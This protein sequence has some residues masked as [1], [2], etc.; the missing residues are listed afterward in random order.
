[1]TGICFCGRQARGFAWW[2]RGF[3]PVPCCSMDCLKIAMKRKGHMGLNFD[4]YTAVEAAGD[5]VGEFL[6]RLGKTDLAALTR[7]EWLDFV[8][9]AYECVCIEVR[10]KW[11]AGE[12]PF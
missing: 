3:D 8:A 12:A 9:H 2:L 6:E 10:A 7:E 1:M 11:D 4:E 5:K